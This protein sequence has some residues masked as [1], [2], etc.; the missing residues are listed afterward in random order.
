MREGGGNW[1]QRFQGKSK[2]PAEW[3]EIGGG[4]GWWELGTKGKET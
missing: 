2:E 1:V 3:R 4:K